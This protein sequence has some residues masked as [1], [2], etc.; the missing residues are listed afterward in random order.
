MRDSNRLEI[1]NGNM[2]E[3]VENVSCGVLTVPDD[4]LYGIVLGT[5]FGI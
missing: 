2:G 1:W 3:E 4:L 5:T